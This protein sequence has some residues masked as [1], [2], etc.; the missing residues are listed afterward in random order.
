[1]TPDELDTYFTS[2]DRTKDFTNAS[3]YEEA[4]SKQEEGKDLLRMLRDG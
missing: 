1:M 2:L 4:A 3:K